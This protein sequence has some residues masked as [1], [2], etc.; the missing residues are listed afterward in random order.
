M[1]P[2][3][4]YRPLVWNEEKEKMVTN[5]NEP[6]WTEQR[7]IYN[8]PDMILHNVLNVYEDNVNCTET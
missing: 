3:Y 6:C 8:M 5:Y 1:A 2:D 7:N 4:D